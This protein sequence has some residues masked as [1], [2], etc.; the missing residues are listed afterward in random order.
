LNNP[1]AKTRIAAGVV[2]GEIS[3]EDLPE[4]IKLLKK[5]SEDGSVLAQVAL[6]Y[7]YENGIGLR[8]NKSEAVK[9]YRYAAQRGNRFAFS[10]LKRLYDEIRP[11]DSEFMVY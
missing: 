6:G 5:S 1:E 9:Y 3:S 7:A 4:S 2:Y 10:E 11:A 8:K